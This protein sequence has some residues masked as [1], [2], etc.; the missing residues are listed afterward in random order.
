MNRPLTTRIAIV[1]LLAINVTMYSANSG[2]WG[3]PLT[4][5]L[6]NPAPLT[7]QL[8]PTAMQVRP[9]APGEG[10]DHPVVGP[11][12]PDVKVMQTDLSGAAAGQQPDG[13]TGAASGA[14]APTASPA[15]GGS[16][17]I[18]LPVAT[19]GASAALGASSLGVA[20]A[21]QGTPAAYAPPATQAP[22]APAT[23]ATGPAQKTPGAPKS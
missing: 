22:S 4:A 3:A 11:P 5:G 13:A 20:S 10:D 9:L 16:S 8:N 1:L 23:K 2:L 17:S 12:V 15:Q 21:A 6:R 7:S 18:G 14:S 19:A